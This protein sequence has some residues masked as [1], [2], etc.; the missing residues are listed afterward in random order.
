VTDV[1]KEDRLGAVDL[2]ELI[3]ALFGIVPG[4][5]VGDRRLELCGDEDEEL[6]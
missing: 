1:T 2:R 3:C 4:A 5:A 6:P